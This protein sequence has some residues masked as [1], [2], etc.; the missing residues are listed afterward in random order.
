MLKLKAHH[1]RS[2]F[3]RGLIKLIRS[4]VLAVLLLPAPAMAASPADLLDAVDQ[5]MVDVRLLHDASFSDP[6][7]NKLLRSEALYPRHIL[8]MVRVVQQKANTLAWLNGAETIAVGP[9]P[10][11]KVVPEDI[12]ANIEAVDW[13]I[14]GVKPEFGVKADARPEPRQER[15]SFNEV[16]STLH[17]MSQLIVGLSVP[18]IVSNNIYMI[19][20]SIVFEL[21][22]L[23]NHYLKPIELKEHY[24]TFYFQAGNES[25][26]R[27]K[28]LNDVFESSFELADALDRLITLRP[29]LAPTGGILRPHRQDGHIDIDHINYALND[30]LA[31]VLAMKAT[32]GNLTQPP[33]KRLVSGTTP[34]KVFDRLQDALRL[35][36]ALTTKA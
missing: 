7:E 34:T 15:P 12:L 14:D 19:V 28:D 6:T 10:T 13:I 17:H 3:A 2:N 11:H 29:E 24:M 5:L 18:G 4:V 35:I 9:T 21:E 36:E 33:R 25:E 27:T 26:N 16:Y 23:A 1:D 31:D 30:M 8:Q 20:D 22:I 32:T